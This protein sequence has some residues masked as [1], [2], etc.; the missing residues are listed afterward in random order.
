MLTESNRVW[1]RGL[2]GE[3]RLQEAGINLHLV[4]GSPRRIN[5]YLL[6]DRDARTYQRL[7]AAE[8]AN[9]LL[10]GHTHSPGTIATGA[11]SS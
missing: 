11:C 4:H 6:E 10:F 8:E 5:E 1:L 3:L 9:V 2:P 7:A